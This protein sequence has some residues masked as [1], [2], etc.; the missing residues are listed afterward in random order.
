LGAALGA[1]Q[2]AI[3]PLRDLN[4]R[5]RDMAET[6]ND[7]GDTLAKAGR[8]AESDKPLQEAQGMAQDLKNS[9]LQA[10]I[11]NSQGDIQFYSGNWKQAGVLYQQALR[12]A[13]RGTERNRV[14]IVK[15]NL[16]RVANADG[17]SQSVINDLR[18]L[19]EEAD[20]QGI[21]YL[22]LESKVEVGAALVNTK[23]YARA[24]QELDHALEISERLGTRIQ[25]AR[26][27]FLIGEAM[28]LAGGGA[29]AKSQ[30]TQALSILDGVKKEPGA[31]HTLDRADLKAV[32]DSAT[33]YSQ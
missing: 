30:Y 29:D 32:V 20:R 26:I 25:S 31:D 28:R 2:D 21:K 19:S 15:L 17:R 10:A 12:E 14:L 18:S 5:T 16:A 33:R 23:D 11:L 27:H 7:Y 8:G 22:A 9:S 6:L 13:T 24:R 3:K 1:M 4:D